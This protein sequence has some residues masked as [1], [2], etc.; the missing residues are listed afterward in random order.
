MGFDKQEVLLETLRVLKKGGTFAIHDIMDWLHF[1]DMNSFVTKL[2]DI[3]F[4][5]VHLV[6]TSKGMFIT[7]FESFFLSLNGSYLL[8]GKK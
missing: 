3:G 7:E 6:D 5:E 8:Y 2:K 1:G 4:E